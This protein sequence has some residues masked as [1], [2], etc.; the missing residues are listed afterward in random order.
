MSQGKLIIISSPSG[1]GKDA[2]INALLKIF[3]NSARLVT[4]TSRPPR[5]G[6]KE[7]VD[8]FFISKNE[9][10]EKIKR[11]AFVEHNI[12]SE[13]YYGIEKSRL[14]ESLERNEIV[15]T[16]IEVNGKHNLDKNKIKHLSIYLL[17]ESLNVLQARIERRGGLDDTQIA[18]RLSI[19][20][21]EMS[22]S[23]DYDYRVV[24][25]QGKLEETVSK[26]ADTIKQELA[27]D[28]KP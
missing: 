9:F 1:G 21:K 26:I 15:F 7:G 13:N 18:E 6:N 8:Y 11:G 4:T 24:N 3:P 12:Y 10:E 5:P 22:E 25:V 14:A 27:I 17:P 2:V 23:I 20:K 16:Q 28:K 19:A